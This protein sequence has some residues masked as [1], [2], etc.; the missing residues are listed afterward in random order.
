MREIN[1]LTGKDRKYSQI[2]NR[3]TSYKPFKDKPMDRGAWKNALITHIHIHTS[4]LETTEILP[5]YRDKILKSAYFQNNKF[6][7]AA[8]GQQ[9][10]ITQFKHIIH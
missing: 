6:K 3:S 8:T 5:H 7:Y 4:L 10:L 1:G 2:T 9:P